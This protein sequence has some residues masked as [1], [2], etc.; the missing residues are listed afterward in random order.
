MS[1]ESSKTNKPAAVKPKVGGAKSASNPIVLTRPSNKLEAFIKLF[2]VV[3]LG[4]LLFFIGQIAAPLVVVIGLRIAGNDT[5]QIEALF[6]DNIAVQLGLTALIA[7]IITLA[8]WKLLRWRGHDPRSFLLLNKRPTMSELFEVVLTYGVY[9]ITLLLATFGLAALEYIL[10]PETPLIDLN[11]SQDLGLA[12]TAGSGL[13]LVFVMLVIIPPIFEEIFF[14]GFLYRYLSGF[15]GKVIGVLL[16]SILFGIAHLEFGSLNW[17]AAIDTFIF[18]IFLIYI[19]H[20]HQSLYSA[21][22]L[23]AMKNGIAFYVL[24]LR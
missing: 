19:S 17:I 8:I 15:G 18:S 20:K 2:G 21:I 5:D 14:R 12:T 23:H 1:K 22:L 24:F 11:Q 7:G 16:T 6:Q 10:S 9:F 13:W 4:F 3:L